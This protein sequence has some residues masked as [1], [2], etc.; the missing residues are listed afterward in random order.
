LS[1]FDYLSVFSNVYLNRDGQTTY[2][3]QQN[4]QPPPTQTIEH[5]DGPEHMT[6]A[7]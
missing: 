7:I 4:E 1:I 6:F 5:K 2:L 3:H